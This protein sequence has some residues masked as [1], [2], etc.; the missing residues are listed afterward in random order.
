MFIEGKQLH[1]GWLGCGTV[2]SGYGESI[3]QMLA[4]F[5]GANIMVHRP[6]DPS[7]EVGVAHMPLDGRPLEQLASPVKILY[8]MFEATRW[9]D[10]EVSTANCANEMWVPSKWCADTLRNSGCDRPIRIIPLGINADVYY[11]ATQGKRPKPFTIG[12]AGA[13]HTRKGIDILLKAFEEEFPGEDVRLRV[14]SQTYFSSMFPDDPRI[15]ILTGLHTLDQM[16]EF[17]QSLD[18]FVL[19]TRGEGFGL[20]P[21]EA[22][23]CGI[24]TA[25]TDFGGCRDY[26][27]EDSLRI[28]ARLVPCA[29]YR[30]CKGYWAEPSLQAVRY[31]MRWA[32]ENRGKAREMGLA[33]SKRVRSEWTWKHTALAMATALCQV[34]TSVRIPMETVTIATWTGNP[35]KVGTRIGRFIRGVPREVTEEE[36]ALLSRSDIDCGNFKVEFCYKRTAPT[37]V[38]GRKLK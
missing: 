23:A 35:L 1:I 33:A 6:D 5:P 9:P 31:A 2:G 11:P 34:D 7:L 14:R 28:A 21:L 18:L 3:A 16:R 15:E 25:V 17:Y 30:S 20:T 27:A 24:C 8:S 29:E 19:P 10:S 32:S 13:A 4:V 36:I 22:M 12:Y 26:I 38:S 37:A